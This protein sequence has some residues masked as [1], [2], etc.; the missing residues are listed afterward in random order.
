MISGKDLSPKMQVRAELYRAVQQLSE[1]SPLVEQYLINT[2]LAEALR[3]PEIVDRARILLVEALRRH[4]DGVERRI[5]QLALC[6]RRKA[7]IDTLVNPIQHAQQIQ[8]FSWIQE[9]LKTTEIN[10][11]SGA[12]HTHQDG[13]LLA[14]PRIFRNFAEA[15]TRWS[16]RECQKFVFKSNYI[17]NSERHTVKRY[18]FKTNRDTFLHCVVV[19]PEFCIDLFGEL[20]APNPHILERVS[21]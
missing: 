18:R 14:S 17:Y 8:F 7:L 3:S 10:Q 1:P 20:P 16:W 12:I 19:R 15:A 13:L 4:A 11:V 6:K 2:L 21:W 9:Q 5:S